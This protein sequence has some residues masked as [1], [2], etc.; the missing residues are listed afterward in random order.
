MLPR[1][2]PLLLDTAWRR[3]Q[4]RFANGFRDHAPSYVFVLHLV[5]VL[6]YAVVNT[7]PAACGVRP[8]TSVCWERS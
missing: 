6:P 3:F 8:P 1:V 5:P 7:L 2:N 4:S